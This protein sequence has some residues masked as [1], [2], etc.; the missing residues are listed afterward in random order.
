[1]RNYDYPDQPE[2]CYWQAVPPQWGGGS[3]F[4]ALAV[5][6]FNKT[7]VTRKQK[8][9]KS[10]PRCEMDRLSE[11][12]K[13]AIDKILGPIAKNG[14]FWPKSEFL[15]QKTPISLL[16]PCSGHYREKLC[17]YKRTLFPNKY[18]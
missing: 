9:E 15:G 13:R 1:M 11:G 10:I 3:F 12:Y 7:T 16:Y 18:K 8:V 4:G 2:R 17:K 14:L 5:F 6:F